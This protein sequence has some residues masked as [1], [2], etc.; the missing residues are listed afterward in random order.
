MGEIEISEYTKDDRQS[1]LNLLGKAFPGI[2][3]EP[4][5]RWRFESFDRPKP[6][7]VC[8]K[9]DGKVVAMHTWL[10]WEFIY[11]GRKYMGYQG[12]EAATDKLYRGQG[13]QNR[14]VNHA[15]KLA[16]EKDIDFLYGAGG[17]PA[18]IKALCNSGFI[19]VAFFPLRQKIIDP[20]Q[21]RSIEVNDIRQSLN[22]ML[23]EEKRITPIV[24]QTYMEWRYIKNPK[25][26][27][28]VRFEKDNNQ[29]LF[30][31]RNRKHRDKKLRITYNDLLILDCQFSSFNHR[32]IKWAFNNLEKMH[33]RKAFTLSIFYNENSDRGR[34]IH[35]QFNF[36]RS[37]HEL[38]FTIRPIKEDLDLNAFFNHYNWDV[39]P[40][41]VDWW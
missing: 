38:A 9:F 18:T 25:N 11:N 31:V 22:K 13:I 17:V 20:F 32:F 37:S 40:H 3:D 41:I 15:C 16:L 14:I 28:I 12:G 39:L 34:A 19:P 2:S 23:Y 6:L 24:D 8:A 7:I 29:A 36:E 35:K 27:S 1:C 26:Y 4:N 10:P 33:A 30:C 5:F 21:K